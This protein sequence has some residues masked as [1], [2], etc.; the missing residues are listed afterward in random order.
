[1]LKNFA[2]HGTLE[3]HAPGL[4]IMRAANRGAAAFNLSLVGKATYYRSNDIH[5]LGGTWAEV[6]GDTLDHIR[7]QED[8]FYTYLGN[9]VYYVEV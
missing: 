8:E 6:L 7:K 5:I 4:F 3:G 1:M 9:Y 2:V